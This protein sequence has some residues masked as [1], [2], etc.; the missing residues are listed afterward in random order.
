MNLRQGTTLIETVLYLGILSAALLAVAAFLALASATRVK[1]RSILEVDQA[2]TTVLEVMTQAIRNATAVRE[3]AA[4]TVSSRLELDGASPSGGSMVF[5]LVDGVV[6]VSMDGADPV[7]LTDGRETVSLFLISDVSAPG[8]PS[9][10]RVQFEIWRTVLPGRNE[11]QYNRTFSGTAV[12][13][14]RL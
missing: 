13:R 7:A 3:P 1:A 12:L 2:G 14:T 8:T 4:G 6:R 10:V 11:Y 9:A 5:D